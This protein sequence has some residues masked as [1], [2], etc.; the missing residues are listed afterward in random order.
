VAAILGIVAL[1]V[2]PSAVSVRGEN[3]ELA[4]SEVASALRYARTE[5]VRTCQHHGVEVL[6]GQNQLRVFTLDRPGDPPA[7]QAT[8]DHPVDKRP[9]ELRFATRRFTVGTQID[10]VVSDFTANCTPKDS[11]TFDRA[12]LPVCTQPT[13][14]RATQWEVSLVAGSEQRTVSISR[15]TGRVTIQ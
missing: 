6:A 13:A 4:A 12:G 2:I 14:A 15:A 1:V 10:Q 8:I 9:Y 3:L 5:A 11:V 7:S